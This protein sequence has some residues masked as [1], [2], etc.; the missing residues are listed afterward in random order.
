M[1][2]AVSNPVLYDQLESAF[3]TICPSAR[4]KAECERLRS[5]YEHAKPYP[6]VVIDGLYDTA[7]LEHIRTAF[8]TPRDRDWIIWNT[9]NEHKATSRGARGVSAFTQLFL[10]L[11]QTADYIDALERITGIEGLLPDPLFHGAGLQDAFRGGFLDIHADYTRHP[12]LPLKRRVN[13]LIYLNRDWNRDWGGDIELWDHDTRQC[14]ASYAP[15]FN[16]TLIFPTTAEALHGHPVPLTCPPDCSRKLISIYYW[17][18]LDGTDEKAEP[19]RW[20]SRDWEAWETKAEAAAAA[21]S[22]ILT[23]GETFVL[24]DD[25]LLYQEERLADY[26]VLP[27]LEKD[28]TYY[29]APTDD[30]TAIDALEQARASGARLIVFAWPAFWWLSHYADF[31][32]HIRNNFRCLVETECLTIFDLRP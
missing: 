23:K 21:I 24:V 14:G 8:P 11:H 1:T 32:R 20:Y 3:S 4:L 31:G 25:G 12:V 27:F 2:D 9:A 10:Q 17:S 15:L 30:A 7:V 26:S 16:R 19:I 13:V 22:D 29:G 6:H 5:D 18:A 28:G